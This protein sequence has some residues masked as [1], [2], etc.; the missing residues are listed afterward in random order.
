MVQMVF[1]LVVVIV[2]IHGIV[3]VVKIVDKGRCCFHAGGFFGLQ[4]GRHS[5]LLWLCGVVMAAAAVASFVHTRMMKG[6][7]MEE[8]ER[9]LEVL[10]SHRCGCCECRWLYRLLVL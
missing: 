1:L 8:V 4:K 3:V 7:R 2:R 10:R 6:T 9:R 5:V